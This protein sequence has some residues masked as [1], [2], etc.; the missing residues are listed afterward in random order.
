MFFQEGV[1]IYV[2]VAHMVED[3]IIKGRLLPEDAVPSTNY[4]ARHYQINPA[5]VGKGFSLLVEEQILYK[6]RGIGM[7]VTADAKKRIQSKRRK[8][9][10]D[11][12]L[13]AMVQS[14]QEIGIS[15]DE[16]LQAIQ[17]ETEKASL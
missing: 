1:S 6:K 11:V 14:A 7:F 17:K 4:F 10:F 13:P 3:E 16:L 8:A 5:T 12:Q 2:Q 15:T 9:F